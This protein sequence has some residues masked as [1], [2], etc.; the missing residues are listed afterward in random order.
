LKKAGAPEAPLGNDSS[1]SKGSP[2]LFLAGTLP[3]EMRAKQLRGLA[4]NYGW[5]AGF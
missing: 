2:P 5:T 1:L 4:T 3:G